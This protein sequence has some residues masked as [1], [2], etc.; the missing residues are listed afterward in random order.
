MLAQACGLAVCGCVL[1]PH[2]AMAAITPA[3]ARQHTQARLHACASLQ[4]NANNLLVVFFKKQAVIFFRLLQLQ[5]GL[6]Q[7]VS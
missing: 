6:M 5:P 3:Q 2:K 1:V 4:M 7:L